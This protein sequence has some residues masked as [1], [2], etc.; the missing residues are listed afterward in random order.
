MDELVSSNVD[1]IGDF[2]A[3]A[4]YPFVTP[5]VQADRHRRP[6]PIGSGVVVSYREKQLLLTACHVTSSACAS[7]PGG[8]LYGFVPE[9][10][11]VEG[12]N[13][14]VDDP[15]DLS[16]TELPPAP[17]RCLRLPRHL[18]PEIRPGE[19][20][21]ILGFP[22]RSKSWEFNYFQHTL[23]PAPLSYLARVF[24]SEPGRFSVR[25]SSKRTYRNGKKLPQQAKL[26]GIS[27]GGAFVLRDDA[28]RLAVIVIEYHSNTAEIICTDSLAIWTML[29]QLDPLLT[30]SART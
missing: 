6:T 26:N 27:G 12:T 16:V 25:F 23:R 7:D 4:V 1:E 24:R 28:P 2:W 11:E 18:A 19:L 30:S 9:Q 5:I 20:C 15:F 21:L 3:K 17:R 10:W 14:H 8:A 22:A 29:K 13:H